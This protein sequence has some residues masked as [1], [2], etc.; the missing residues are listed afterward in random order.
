[1]H[2]AKR[3][4]AN[5]RIVCPERVTW[6]EDYRSRYHAG[7]SIRSIA[8]DTRPLVRIRPPNPD[9][10]RRRPPRTWWSPNPPDQMSILF[11]ARTGCARSAHR[12][13]THH[14]SR[15]S[16]RSAGGRTRTT[17]RHSRRAVNQSERQESMKL[18]NRSTTVAVALVGV[19]AVTAAPASAIVGGRDATQTYPGVAAA[20]I[21]F[22]E[23]GTALCGASVM[24]PQWALIAA[25]CVS[26]HNAAPTPIAMLGSNVSL[27]VGTNDRT[28][29]G[30]VVTGKQVYLYPGRYGA[31]PG[32]PRRSATSRWWS[33]HSRCTRRSC[34]STSIRHPREV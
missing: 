26:D 18:L 11:A 15:R 17:P 29:G 6:T 32:P 30:H 9:R 21:V 20:K 3:Q 16:P 31:S 19:L 10:R 23:L 24:H 25:H 34:R 7:H 27:R 14:R 28:T 33:W 22:P 13:T 2:D 12:G 5:R 8:A 4:P 1:M